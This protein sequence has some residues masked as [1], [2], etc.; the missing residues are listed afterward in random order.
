MS[1]Y[2]HPFSTTLDAITHAMERAGVSSA[3]AAHRAVGV[4]YRQTIIQATT[5]AY[6]DVLHAFAVMAAIMIPFLWLARRGNGAAGAR[7]ATAHP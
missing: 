5:L 3:T 1:H 2:D 7:P 4:L 6:L